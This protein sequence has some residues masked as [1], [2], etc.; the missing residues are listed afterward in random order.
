MKLGLLLR[1]CRKEVAVRAVD[2]ANALRDVRFR[3]QEYAYLVRFAAT[4]LLLLSD[5]IEDEEFGEIWHFLDRA[6]R[7]AAHCGITFGT[8]MKVVS[9]LRLEVLDALKERT[10]VSD[11]GAATEEE[12]ELLSTQFDLCISKIVDS[13]EKQ[14]TAA[15]APGSSVVSPD[16]ARLRKAESGKRQYPEYSPVSSSNISS[17]AASGWELSLRDSVRAAL[18]SEVR[19]GSRMKELRRN[20]KITLR[21]LAERLGF[22]RG[23][24]SNIENGK[25]SPSF[26]AISA[27][28]KVLDPSGGSSLILLGMIE[29]LPQEV[30]EILISGREGAE[31]ETGRV[32]PQQT[33]MPPA[34]SEWEEDTE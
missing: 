28:S 1:E 22:A 4:L 19:F 25:T 33:V 11:S 30:R 31:K 5:R 32:E 9:F 6:S 26:T 10:K 23:Y 20:Q 16:N 21:S 18:L 14:M 3:Q 24:I 7:E 2:R 12:K 15:T 13:F 27:I 8:L 29:R 17:S 34:E